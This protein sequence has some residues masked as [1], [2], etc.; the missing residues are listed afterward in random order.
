MPHVAS[1]N[2]A[3]ATIRM[4]NNLS[5]HE[6]AGKDAGRRIVLFLGERPEVADDQRCGGHEDHG[7]PCFEVRAEPAGDDH[8]RGGERGG[9]PCRTPTHGHTLR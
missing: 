6:N 9:C 5:S 7:V 8:K 2:K 1:R 3:L 4:T